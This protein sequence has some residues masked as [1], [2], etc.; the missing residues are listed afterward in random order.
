[1]KFRLTKVGGTALLMMMLALYGQGC[2]S[3]S[4]DTSSSSGGGTTVANTKSTSSIPTMEFSDISNSDGKASSS[5]SKGLVEEKRNE[6]D[7]K[8]LFSRMGCEVNM[9]IEEAS[10]HMD[11]ANSMFCHMRKAEKAGFKIGEETFVYNV[12][13]VPE[14]PKEARE[15]I[16]E[17]RKGDRELRGKREDEVDSPEEDFEIEGNTMIIRAGNF[18]GTELRVDGAAQLPNG[19]ILR[20]FEATVTVDDAA[21]KLAGIVINKFQHGGSEEGSRIDISGTNVT[22]SDG[23]IVASDKA[24]V[25]VIGQITG[26]WGDVRLEYSHDK[27]NTA[28]KVR[29]YHKGSFTDPKR[30]VAHNTTT[31]A[32]AV[33]NASCGCGAGEFTGQVP[34][35]PI[36]S[37]VQNCPS[38]HRAAVVQGIA[39]DEGLVALT[40]SSKVCPG[41]NGMSIADGDRCTVNHTFDECYSIA[42]KDISTDLGKKL[43]KR[44][45]AVVPA[46]ECKSPASLNA[47]WEN[48]KNP[49]VSVAFTRDWDG[50]VPAGETPNKVDVTTLS[51]SDFQECMA[52][53]ER[54]RERRGAGGEGCH[55][56]EQRKV[57]ENEA[58][59][60]GYQLEDRG[61]DADFIGRQEDVRGEQEDPSQYRR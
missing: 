50:T 30:G 58:K 6:S 36:S 53:E 42:V 5:L 38:Q 3:S 37:L 16:D 49:E 15:R 48:I 31:T 35:I 54:F 39:Q 28:D 46:S 55:E 22:V 1:M 10:R 61:N 4:D 26:H 33:Q 11:Q 41:P 21:K 18:G 51:P 52:F 59:D 60:D 13:A 47:A 25:D 34:A 43:K 14:P 19:K 45:Y 7:F 32:R 40:A 8:A 24:I 20:L 17:S 27:A 56:Q 9:R 57:V 29:F 12:I 44:K 23:V 2:G